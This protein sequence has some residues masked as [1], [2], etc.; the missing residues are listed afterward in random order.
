MVPGEESFFLE[1]VQLRKN[2]SFLAMEA[3][4]QFFWNRRV[5][6]MYSKLC[7]DQVSSYPPQ[8]MADI[9]Y[10]LKAFGVL[11]TEIADQSKFGTQFPS[12]DP[13][14]TVMV[15]AAMDPSDTSE[16]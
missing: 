10:S 14:P 1:F 6:R 5:Q 15:A 13:K 12:F 7:H 2:F 16:F 3:A 4:L 9:L 8:Q 11:P